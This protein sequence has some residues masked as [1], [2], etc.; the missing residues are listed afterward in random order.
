MTLRL[1]VDVV[2]S[3]DHFDIRIPK[4]IGKGSEEERSYIQGLVSIACKFTQPRR[5]NICTS[6]LD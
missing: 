5:R 6:P 1:L 2:I 4:G 3:V